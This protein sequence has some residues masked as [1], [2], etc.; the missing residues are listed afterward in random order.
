LLSR[1]GHLRDRLTCAL[2]PRLSVRL[3]AYVHRLRREP[4]IA[5]LQWFCDSRRVSLDIGANRGQFAYFLRRYSSNVIC[6]EPQPHLASYLRR[7]LGDAAAVRECALSDTAGRGILHVPTIDGE[8]DNDGLASLKYVQIDSQPCKLIEVEICCLDDIGLSDVGFIKID[9]EGLE[10]NVLRGGIRSIER[11]RPALLVE[12]ERRHSCGAPQSVFA[13]LDGIGY[14]GYFWL[15]GRWHPV[16]EF[17]LD[18]HQ[19]ERNA[20]DLYGDP[21]G[22]YVNNFLFL[23]RERT[24]PALPGL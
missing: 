20:P 18:V 11:D 6:F 12:S 16:C 21:R 3:R 23:P 2:P 5:M 19:N 8:R 10:T 9:V 22:C 24:I 13:L 17:C 4:E 7:S 1:G 14:R 15:D